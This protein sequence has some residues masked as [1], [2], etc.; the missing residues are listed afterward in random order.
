[1]LERAAAKGLISAGFF[2]R[3]SFTST[4]EE[5]LALLPECFRNMFPGKLTEKQGIG[6]LFMAIVAR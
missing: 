3:K 6:K 2:R 1:M 4:D 5:V